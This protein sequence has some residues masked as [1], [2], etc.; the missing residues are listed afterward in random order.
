MAV[1]RK[2]LSLCGPSRAVVDDDCLTEKLPSRPRLYTRGYGIWPAVE[3]QNK[4]NFTIESQTDLMSCVK[5]IT[6][7]IIF[8]LPE[9][10]S[11]AM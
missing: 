6:R 2:M 1:N 5:K 10:E 11:I 9:S 4:I 7:V 8:P 3:N